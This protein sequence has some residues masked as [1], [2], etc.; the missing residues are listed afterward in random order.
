MELTEYDFWR[1]IDEKL[2]VIAYGPKPEKR[3]KFEFEEARGWF[4]M[5]IRK[6]QHSDLGDWKC[7]TKL[8]FKNGTI[9]EYESRKKAVFPNDSNNTLNDGITYSDAP[10]FR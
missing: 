3:Y 8:R 10:L 4:S 9:L 1:G 7:L 5:K 2:N 6:L